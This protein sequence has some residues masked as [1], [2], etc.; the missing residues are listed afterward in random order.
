MKRIL[1]ILAL[2]SGFLFGTVPAAGQSCTRSGS[3]LT[4]ST[5]STAAINT[6]I[7][8]LTDGDTI[9][10]PS[11]TMTAT[12]AFT[13]F[14]HTVTFQGAGSSA[15]IIN[16]NQTGNLFS[17]TNNCNNKTFTFTGIK[18]ADS[19]SLNTSNAI[20]NTANCY[21]PC[22]LISYQNAYVGPTS[23]TARAIWLGG[24]TYGVSSHDSYT[25]IG[26]QA[27]NWISSES[28][29]QFGNAAWQLPLRLGTSNCFYYEDDTWDWVNHVDQNDEE[30]GACVHYR[31][32]VTTLHPGALTTSGNIGAFDHGYDS[33]PRS[34]KEVGYDH[35]TYIGSCYRAQWWRG[36]TG[37]SY[38]NQFQTTSC[39]SN[40][41]LNIELTNY[42]SDS[43]S[44]GQAGNAKGNYCNGL[45]SVDGNL[46]G[47]T[48][49]GWPCEDQFG[50]GQDTGPGTAQSA[51]SGAFWDNC[52]N[53]LGGCTIGGANEVDPVV[54]DTYAGSV[55]NNVPHDILI[56]RDYFQPVTTGSGHGVGTAGV[57]QGT[58]A[59]RPATC[60]TIAHSSGPY[61][62]ATDTNT[63]YNCSSTN[64]W[65]TYYTPYTY[66]NPL[67]PS[68]TYS[69]TVTSTNGTV[70]GSLC[71]TASGIA[72]G[73]TIGACTATANT[74]YTFTGWSGTGS[75]S[76]VSGTSPVSFAL[77]ANSTLTATMTANSYTVTT[78]T[79]GSGSG[80]VTGCGGST[81]FGTSVSCTA[82][83]TSGT[84]TGWSGGV[85]TGTTNPC[86]FTMP[87]S[88]LTVT[89]N[90][91]NAVAHPTF[92]PAAGTYG[93]TQSVTISSTT[94]GATFCYTVDGSTPTTDG[95]GNCV[96]GFQYASP[97]SVSTSETI[98]AIGTKAGY[99]D[100]SVQSAAYVINGS[101]AN[102]TFSPAGGSYGASQTVTL[103]TATGSATICYTTDG[104]TPT[105][106]GNGAC[107]GATLTYSTPL[108]VS[109]TQTITAIA[110]KASFVDSS[111]TSANYM[112]NG[113]LP[114]PTFS[115][116]GGSYGGTQSVTISAT[117]GSSVTLVNAMQET[118]NSNDT[119]G[120]SVHRNTYTNCAT[121]C[122]G[123]TPQPS[124]AGT[125]WC[126]ASQVVS[127]GS[128][129]SSVVSSTISGTGTSNLDNGNGAG[130]SDSPNSVTATYA[131]ASTGGCG[132]HSSSA[133]GYVSGLTFPD[134]GANALLTMGIATGSPGNTS[135][136]TVSKYNSNGDAGRFVAQR[137]CVNVSSITKGGQH[138]ESDYNYNT[139]GGTYMGFGKDFDYPN[140]H[141]RAAPQGSSWI[142][143]ELCP[144]LGGSCVSTYNWPLADY[145]VIESYEHWDAGCS[146]SSSSACAYYDAIGIQPYSGGSPAGSMVYYTVRNASTHATISF[147]PINKTSWTHPQYGIQH[148][149]DINQSSQS[150][151][152]NIDYSTA[153]AYFPVTGS[154]TICYTTDGTTPTGDGAGSCTHGTTYSGPISISS[155]TTVKAIATQAGYLDSAV[156]SATYTINGTAATPTFSPVAGT[157]TSTQSVALSSATGGATICYTTDGT[158][159]TADGAGT[160]THGTA[161]STAVSVAVSLTLQA[162]ASEAGFTDSSVGSAAYVITAPS[163]PRISGT[164]TLKGVTQIQ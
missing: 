3:T 124:P 114:T 12:S 82:N 22:I 134:P 88:N 145:L 135:I 4:P 116:A 86:V 7:S 9:S 27:D 95:N 16:N 100:S 33:V 106:D 133:S 43:G 128:F 80:T 17:N 140:K 126:N 60:S 64:V 6:C 149:W 23:N 66:P 20:I 13:A 44:V 119:L 31:H 24:T 152:A 28:G 18:V 151:Q 36:G 38:S 129:G 157:Y 141:W 70:T 97:I 58:L 113:T 103:A 8:T 81:T 74:G 154:A 72:A 150:L 47:I 115:P 57:G 52:N 144:V 93:P 94:S 148:Q 77:N 164:V 120:Q 161:Y 63:L 160:C 55:Q 46:S 53:G 136:L 109:T 143:E 26:N 131:G 159:P 10:L 90:F 132:A 130:G 96:H 75:A 30:N 158:T 83:V 84:F 127:C 39:G 1:I 2:I 42:R 25:D 61:Y 37:I 41:N 67:L 35:N 45:I 125:K 104:S 117:G 56:N 62:W 99:T 85:C 71:S 32:N 147:I 76:G 54:T 121:S 69:L 105:T 111:V 118:A 122:S 92:S 101:V 155:T 89:A 110:T 68:T 102:V 40:P 98:K 50:R 137:D 49:D 11:G 65:S 138:Y 107:T 59:Q 79:A 123:G 48:N 19:A 87:A 108:T 153:V 163:A 29:A 5:L 51:A 139:S 91:A 156:G 112:I 78:S 34:G 15:T 146:Y 162:I 21:G 73:T 14:C 142:V